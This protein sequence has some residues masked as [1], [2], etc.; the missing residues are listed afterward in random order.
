MED[1]T[2]NPITAAKEM[3]SLTGKLIR[4]A[5][6][7][8][9]VREAGKPLGLA[10]VTISKALNVCL[11]PLAAINLGYE[12]AREYFTTR[13][14]HDL[15]VCLSDVPAEDIVEPKAYVAGPAVQ[16]RCTHLSP[17]LRPQTDELV[18]AYPLQPLR[19]PAASA[20]DTLPQQTPYVVG[21]PVR[22]CMQPLGNRTFAGPFSRCWN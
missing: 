18:P 1:E 5:G 7:S 17:P 19:R 8:P 6:D 10:A 12:K 22:Q 20:R 13:F 21:L 9:D 2:V 4:A 15:E 14:E 16:G 3:A 11:L